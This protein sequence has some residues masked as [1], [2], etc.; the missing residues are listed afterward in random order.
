MPAKNPLLSARESLQENLLA[1][2][3][4]LPQDAQTRACQ[5]VVDAFAPL[6]EKKTKVTRGVLAAQVGEQGYRVK[7]T[8]N[9]L[10]IPIGSMLSKERA[11][12]LIDEGIIVTVMRNS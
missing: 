4:G 8:T 7:R 5:L 1:L 11:Q 2:M 12:T 10:D 3:D 6:L 9:L